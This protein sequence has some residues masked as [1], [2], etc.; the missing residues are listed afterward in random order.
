M[1]VLILV[2]LIVLLYWILAIAWVAAR[3]DWR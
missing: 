3:R 2:G 1:N